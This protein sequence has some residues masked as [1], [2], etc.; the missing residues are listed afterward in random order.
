ML[1]LS[2]CASNLRTLLQ[3]FTWNSHYKQ[4]SSFY[5]HVMVFW[6]GPAIGAV[7]AALLW[8]LLMPAGESA[9]VEV[10]PLLLLLQ[11]HSLLGNDCLEGPC[12]QAIS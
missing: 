7:A 3:A 4:H 9:E 11:C 6:L 1:R 2:C 8:R 10:L 12:F 5:E